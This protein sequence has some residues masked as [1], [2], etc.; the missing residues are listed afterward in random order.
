MNYNDIKHQ[1][2]NHSGRIYPKQLI[3]GNIDTINKQFNTDLSSLTVG[4]IGKIIKE[5]I[6][7]V[8]LCGKLKSWDKSYI[9]KSCGQ[10][11]CRNINREETSILKYGVSNIAQLNETQNK[12]KNTCNLKYGVD[13]YTQSEDLKNKYKNKEIETWYNKHIQ[14]KEF[15]NKEYIEEH[16]IKDDI[17]KYEEFMTFF[18]IQ[19]YS[20]VYLILNEFDIKLKKIGHKSK[21]ETHIVDF[22]NNMTN[23]DIVENDRSIIS[24]NEIDI[25]IPNNNL[26]VEF[27]GLYWHSYGKNNTNI[28]Q[29]D[30]YFQQNRHLEKTQAFEA[31]SKD[32]KLFHIFENEWINPVTQDIWK[33]MISNRLGKSK[34]VYARKCI[35]KELDSKT[36]NEFIEA[37]H[38]QG[39]RNAK[40]KL[41]LYYDNELISVM[42]FGKPLDNNSIYE[43]ELIRFCNKK[44]INVIGGAS[45]LLKYFERNYKPKSL[46]SY[47]NRRWSKGDLYHK[48]GFTLSNISGPNK[49]IIKGNKLYNRLGFQK[50]KLE[51]ILESFDSSLSADEN[52]IN[53][54]YG[55]IWDCGN[56]VFVKD[57]KHI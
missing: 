36:S 50:H 47:A 44:Y 45:K 13:Y 30:K 48:L 54:N 2:D 33:S 6:N 31:L 10:K 8:C 4:Q 41:G 29:G 37:N 51:N 53:N 24:P 38:I 12:I 57:Y 16:F 17:L 22:L 3:I 40:V 32:H 9:Q 26:G 35:I 39:I 21:Y 20:T 11:I 23:L 1:I 5:N 43:Y 52:I 28:N 34:P 49:F 14:N 15:L 55:L 42:T 19:S 56:Y 7:P 27:N 18:N 46:I 25:T